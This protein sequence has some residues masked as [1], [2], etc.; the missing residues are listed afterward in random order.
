MTVAKAV[1]VH[2]RE[3]SIE[4]E[5]ITCTIQIPR[6]CLLSISAGVTYVPNATSWEFMKHW[7]LVADTVVE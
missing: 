6:R 2:N 1:L 7:A 5:R 3:I 4:A